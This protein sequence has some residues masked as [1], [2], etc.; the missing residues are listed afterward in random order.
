MEKWR[1]R[2]VDLLTSLALGSRDNPAVI[3]YSPAKTRLP[4]NELR[5]FKRSVPE[6][7]GISSKRLY[8]MLCELE[9]EPRANI[10]SLLVLAG[11]EVICECSRDGYDVNMWHLSHSMSKSVT[12][13]I[14]GIL[15]EEGKLRVDERLVDIFPELSYKDK[16]F[17]NITVEHLLTMTSGASFN[18]AGSVT[19]EKWSETFF[20]SPLRFAPGTKFQYNSM[21]TYM[22]ARIVDRR[23]VRGFSEYAKKKLFHPLGIYNYFWEKSPEGT[24]K[25]GWGLFISAESFAKFGMLFLSGGEFYGTRIISEKWISEM[26]ETHAHSPEISGDFNYGYQ[27]WVAR[28][29]DEKLFN[30]MLGQDVWICPRNNIIA[31]INGGNDELFQES[32]ALEIIR[33]HLGGEIRDEL[34]RGSIRALHEK[35]TKFFDCRRWV[36][37]REKKKGVLYL[38]GLKNSVPYDTAWNGILGTYA[39]GSNN[40]GMLPLIVRTMQNNLDSYLEK[41]AL[42]KVDSDVYLSFWESGA[43]YVL[44]VGLYEYKTTVLDFRGEKYIVRAL[45][46]VFINSDGES[47]YRIELIFPELPNTRRIRLVRMGDGKIRIEFFEIPNDRIAE[48]IILRISEINTPLSIAAD[49]IE[50]KFGQGIIVGTIRR[51]FAPILFG[52]DM[53]VPG[54]LETVKAETKRVEEES[55]VVRLIRGVVDRFFKE[56]PEDDKESP[57]NKN[58]E[59]K[60]KKKTILG[61]VIEKINK[62]KQ[63]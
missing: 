28:N 7:F 24:E 16:R 31:V 3:P 23:T 25:G 42:Y 13:M 54:Y 58:T 33:K 51:T 15:V 22:L 11:G 12:S 26:G 61:G 35:E 40:V 46:E 27:T 52:A 19:E 62:K 38:L 10:H 59:K 17:P 5:F 56:T 1:K 39:F 8:A 60:Q 43:H 2:A 14:V 44:Q 50:R 32:A 34:D 6:K 29:S 20:A 45:G 36:R 41:L 21:N 18:E 47:E 55:R 49:L 9:G 48:N 37:P 4:S 53:S 57:K 30:G 63:Q